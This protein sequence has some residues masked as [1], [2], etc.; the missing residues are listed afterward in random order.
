MKIDRYYDVQ[1]DYCGNRL[2]TDFDW[3]L[4]ESSRQAESSARFVGFRT[5]KGKNICPCCGGVTF[6]YNNKTYRIGIYKN[7]LYLEERLVKN[8]WSDKKIIGSWSL[9][10]RKDALI[11]LGKENIDYFDKESTNE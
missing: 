8:R 1:C 5:K 4:C 3:G 7:M 9:P 6:E 10:L 11:K 2:S